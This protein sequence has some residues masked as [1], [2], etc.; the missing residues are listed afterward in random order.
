MNTRNKTDKKINTCV[1]RAIGNGFTVVKLHFL[2]FVYLACI[3]Y[4]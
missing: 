4:I 1:D 3:N 2:N